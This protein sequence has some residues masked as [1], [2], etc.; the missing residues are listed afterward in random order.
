MTQ[1]YGERKRRRLGKDGTDGRTDGADGRGL[2]GLRAHGGWRLRTPHLGV[3]MGAV[4]GGDPLSCTPGHRNGLFGVGGGWVWGVGCGG[5]GTRNNSFPMEGGSRAAPVSSAPLKA[6]QPHVIG[7]HGVGRAATK[8]SLTPPRGT[9]TPPPPPS[10]ARDTIKVCT[11]STSMGRNQT[12]T[13][14]TDSH[15]ALGWGG[16][17]GGTT[18]LLP[19]PEP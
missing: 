13:A 16:G 12:T 17:G 1:S 7:M 15:R 14:K 3:L 5:G 11:N 4:C 18:T 9:S 2:V 8:G 10:P 6:A 19:P